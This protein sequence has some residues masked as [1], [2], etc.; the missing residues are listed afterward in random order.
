MDVIVE[1]DWQLFKNIRDFLIALILSGE[2]KKQRDLD[3]LKLLL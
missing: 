1:K 2:I 3:Y